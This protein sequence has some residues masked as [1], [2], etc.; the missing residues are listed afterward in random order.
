[1]SRHVVHVKEG[2]RHRAG[3]AHEEGIVGRGVVVACVGTVNALFCGMTHLIL[4]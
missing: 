2:G 1:V 3:V 4:N